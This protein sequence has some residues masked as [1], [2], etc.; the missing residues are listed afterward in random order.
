[1]AIANCT[2]KLGRDYIKAFILSGKIK[3]AK[4]NAAIIIATPIIAMFLI[5][6]ACIVWLATL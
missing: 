2:G 6:I 3:E 5:I 4:W 1:M